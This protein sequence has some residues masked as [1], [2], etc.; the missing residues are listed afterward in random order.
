MKMSRIKKTFDDL[1]E[2]LLEFP[3]NFKR[4]LNN[5]SRT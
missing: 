1:I 5:F 2:E 4:M 3:D